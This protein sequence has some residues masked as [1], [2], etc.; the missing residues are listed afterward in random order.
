MLHLLGCFHI[1]EAETIEV[2]RAD[3]DRYVGHL[4][5]IDLLFSSAQ[6]GKRHA[7]TPMDTDEERDYQY[8]THMTFRDRAQMDAA[9][10]HI[11]AHKEPAAN[12]HQRFMSKI[13][14]LVF[15]CW[16]DT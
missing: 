2:L 1:K 4:K 9:Y 13:K 7:D 14:E 6:I 15:L 16:E 11:E 8:F 5:S 3:Y 12:L 10:A